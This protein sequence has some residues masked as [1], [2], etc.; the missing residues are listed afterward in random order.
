M[1]PFPAR[2]F[3]TGGLTWRQF[4][5]FVDWQLRQGRG[6]DEELLHI[7]WSGLDPPKVTFDTSCRGGHSQD[8]ADIT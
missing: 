2:R 8:R 1:L 4:K 6:D 5:A 7:D 3:D